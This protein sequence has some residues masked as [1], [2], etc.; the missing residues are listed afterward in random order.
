MAE[1]SALPAEKSA[2]FIWSWPAIVVLRIRSSTSNRE[3]RW[4][5]TSFSKA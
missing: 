5:C 4:R 2:E 1:F 3:S